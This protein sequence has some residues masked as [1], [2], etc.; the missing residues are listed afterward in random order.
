MVP[1]PPADLTKCL[2]FFFS[3]C[4]AALGG[5]RAAAK[6]DMEIADAVTA[7]GM[8][9]FIATWVRNGQLPPVLPETVI[10]WHRIIGQ[11]KA[12]EMTVSLSVCS[13]PEPHDRA[14][15]L[16]TGPPPQ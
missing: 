5:D 11:A 8:A 10:E 7:A 1:V 16:M 2:A 14:P 4:L 13:A 15:A 6:K 9:D 12:G 3:G